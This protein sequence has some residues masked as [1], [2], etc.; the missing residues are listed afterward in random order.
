MLGRSS[1]ITYVALGDS[2]TAYRHGVKVYS[3]WL[4][5][6]GGAL[7]LATIVNSGV[8]GWNTAHLLRHIDEKCLQYRP[9][10][11]SIMIGTNDH[12]IYKGQRESAVSLELYRRNLSEIIGIIRSAASSDQRSAPYILLMSPPFIASYTNEAG[13]STSQMRLL[14][15]VETMR[16]ISVELGTGY[17]DANA[18]TLKAANGDERLYRLTYTDGNDGV[19]LNTA[20]QRLLLPHLVQA[21]NRP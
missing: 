16:M 21:L 3:E 14:E 17:L 13:T 5:E 20:G 19:H 4:L 8:G 9:Q 11:V 2:I 1:G 18:I 10:L 12:A 15:Y 6:E 7:G